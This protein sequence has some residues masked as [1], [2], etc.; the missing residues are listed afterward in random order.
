MN[1]LISWLQTHNYSFFL[2]VTCWILA[3]YLSRKNSYAGNGEGL[4]WKFS[5]QVEREISILSGEKRFKS[6]VCHI[7]GTLSPH[8]LHRGR[9]Q[10]PSHL[11]LTADKHYVSSTTA[12]G[13]PIGTVFGF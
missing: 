7:L 3:S 8:L 4:L 12:K 13:V 11:G 10:S 1:S 2:F 6:L 9:A 5:G